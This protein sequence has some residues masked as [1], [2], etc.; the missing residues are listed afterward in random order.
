[1]II[2]LKQFNEMLNSGSAAL[3]LGLIA[4]ILL[5]IYLKISKS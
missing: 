5:M 2:D 1:M 4:F 3:L